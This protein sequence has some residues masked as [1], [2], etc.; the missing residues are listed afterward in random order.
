MLTI[1]WIGHYAPETTQILSSLARNQVSIGACAD[2]PVDRCEA[3]GSAACLSDGMDVVRYP[4]VQLVVAAA[5]PVENRRIIAEAL[6]LARPVLVLGRPAAS[7]EDAVRLAGAT[8]QARGRVWLTHLHRYSRAA[9]EMRAFINSQSTPEVLRLDG[10]VILPPRAGRDALW[11]LAYQVCDCVSHALPHTLSRL[12]QTDVVNA[13]DMHLVD[14][15]F[16]GRSAAD[17][18]LLIGHSPQVA[19]QE[20]SLSV[21]TSHGVWAQRAAHQQAPFGPWSP[22]VLDRLWGEVHRAFGGDGTALPGIV[23]GA[24]T[25]GLLERRRT[26]VAA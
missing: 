18:R 13:R 2:L 11:D 16:C 23:D 24:R 21:I 9:T 20:Q 7:A 25:L 19:H 12:E 5:A 1:G 17:A 15:S 10:R 4:N 26:P 14:L 6:T 8:R 22:D 3:T